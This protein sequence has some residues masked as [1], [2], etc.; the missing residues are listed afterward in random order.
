MQ[1]GGCWPRAILGCGKKTGNVQLATS[2][3][4]TVRGS[5]TKPLQGLLGKVSTLLVVMGK[6]LPVLNGPRLRSSKAEDQGLVTIW[7]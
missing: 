5:S 2:I 6:L 3:Y 1:A 4:A 7:I